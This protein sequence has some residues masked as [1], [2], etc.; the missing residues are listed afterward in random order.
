MLYL[1]TKSGG[2]RIKANLKYAIAH[3]KQFKGTLEIAL[4]KY[5]IDLMCGLYY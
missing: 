4:H 3:T 5:K 2:N 1:A